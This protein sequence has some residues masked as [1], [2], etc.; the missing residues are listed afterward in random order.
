MPTCLEP[1][2]DAVSLVRALERF[3]HQIFP[4]KL[5]RVP[6]T[7]FREA[8][9]GVI[10]NVVFHPEPYLNS[11]LVDT[12]LPKPFLG[13][14]AQS[15]DHTILLFLRLLAKGQL[16][17]WGR[18][19]VPWGSW[20]EIPAN[21]LSS[22][23]TWTIDWARQ[24]IS[25]EGHDKPFFSVRV[26]LAAQPD[27]APPSAVNGAPAKRRGGLLPVKLDLVME[28]MREDA[29]KYG[30]KSVKDLTPNKLIE[31][32]GDKFKELIAQYRE[33]P[34][35]LA[36]RY[37]K[38][39]AAVVAQWGEKAKSAGRTTYISARDQL[40][41]DQPQSEFGVTHDN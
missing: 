23:H 32:Y 36:P 20:V 3:A 24:R 11:C 7:T 8:L 15:W 18:E 9:Y 19:Q 13:L 27:I 34:E 39:V 17:L 29:E 38:K 41:S 16:I 30:F 21:A 22:Y 25:P 1:P 10:T 14:D 31:R 35:E 6:P 2:A 40:V 4:G 28:L 12:I 33:K 37:R 5:Y 26:V